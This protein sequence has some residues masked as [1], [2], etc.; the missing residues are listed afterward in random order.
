MKRVSPSGVPG[1][2]D[3][4]LWFLGA[5]LSVGAGTAQDQF[6]TVKG[7]VTWQSTLGTAFVSDAR[8]QVMDPKFGTARK[9]LTGTR[10]NKAGDYEIE[11]LSVG[12]YDI[13]V[14]DDLLAYEPERHPGVSVNRDADLPFKLKAV[15]LSGIE[16]PAGNWK[17][18][19]FKHIDTG[20]ESGPISSD[21]TGVFR[22]KN[23]PP[24]A[25]GLV[26]VYC[27]DTVREADDDSA[28]FE[29]CLKKQITIGLTTDQLIARLTTQPD[30]IIN[31]GR[32][33]IYIY[34]YAKITVVS[35]KVSAF[36][37]GLE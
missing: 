15:H 13:A 24:E 36:A 30:R 20:C 28:P 25:L 26:Y 6:A 3:T 11:N 33:K 32:Q 2:R 4:L 27:F 5:I 17:V 9:V 29:S 37:I 31:Q 8:V 18:M 12:R 7:K 34:K 1:L 22:I 35:G 23:I 16:F 10:G 19:Y 21:A 14:C